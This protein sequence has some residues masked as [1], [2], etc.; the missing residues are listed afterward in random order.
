M[1]M[2]CKEKRKKRNKKESRITSRILTSARMTVSFVD[3][4]E[5]FVGVNV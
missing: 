2:G 1:V 5:D 4:G 3:R